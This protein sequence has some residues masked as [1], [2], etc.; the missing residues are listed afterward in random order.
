M[1]AGTEII[2]GLRCKL[3]MMGVPMDGPTRIRA[4]NMSVVNNCSCPE[5]QL[6]LLWVS[7]GLRSWAQFSPPVF[8]EEMCQGWLTSPLYKIIKMPPAL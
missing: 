8:R 5:S 4:D 1:K 6:I 2:I 7:S 3:H